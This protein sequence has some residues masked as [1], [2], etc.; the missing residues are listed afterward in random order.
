MPV[1]QTSYQNGKIYK[2]WSLETDKIYIGSTCDTLT[3]RIS[4]HRRIYKSWKEGKR[5][6]VSNSVVLFDLVG[7][8][9][10]KI[11]LMKLFPCESKSE[12]EAEEGCVM[13][14]NKDLIVNRCIAG[15]S[16]KEWIDE[17]KEELKIKNKE[18]RDTHKEERKKVK[19]EYYDNNK[20]E[21]NI[22]RSQK[23]N[24]ECGSIYRITDK[25]RHIKTKKHQ[26]FIKPR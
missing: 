15:R 26:D 18:Y 9:N 13:R 22:K 21:I 25:A 17:H 6:N 1:N 24:C 2:I 10:C 12:L 8:E 20:E 4:G 14:A 5:N 23:I 19:K 3:N 7:V 11:E 16:H